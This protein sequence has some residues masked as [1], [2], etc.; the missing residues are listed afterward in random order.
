[1]RG[2]SAAHVRDLAGGSRVEGR[3]GVPG[4]NDAIAGA[5]GV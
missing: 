2:V 4:G 3:F 5:R 1:M